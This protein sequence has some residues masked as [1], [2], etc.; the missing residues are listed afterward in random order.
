MAP[1]EGGASPSRLEKAHPPTLAYRKL[2]ISK[3]LL[4]GWVVSCLCL[5]WLLQEPH[6]ATLSWGIQ[7]LDFEGSVGFLSFYP[8]RQQLVKQGALAD[9]EFLLSLERAAAAAPPQSSTGHMYQLCLSAT[10]HTVT[11]AAGTRWRKKI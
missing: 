1:E 4:S 6:D 10:G 3:N 8:A 9:E 2:L 11:R 5:H 7:E